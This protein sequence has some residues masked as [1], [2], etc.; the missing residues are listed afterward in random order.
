MS[1]LARCGSRSP[2]RAD[3]AAASMG[4]AVGALLRAG[5]H[6]SPPRSAAFVAVP[7]LALEH[8]RRGQ[9]VKVPFR[10]RHSSRAFVPRNFHCIGGAFAIR[11]VGPGARQ[12]PVLVTML[13]AGLQP[14]LMLPPSGHARAAILR[15]TYRFTFPVA[16]FGSSSTNL[17]DL[18]HLYGASDFFTKSRSS[19]ATASP[20]VTPDRRTTTA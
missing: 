8:A 7:P 12:L 19:E 13:F 5:F 6:P 15:R 11:A 1:T 4:A 3:S 14:L 18:G 17:I 20:A 9:H 10:L 2:E 16:V